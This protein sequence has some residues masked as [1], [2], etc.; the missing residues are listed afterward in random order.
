MR[1]RVVWDTECYSEIDAMLA[2]GID[3]QRLKRAVR[4]AADDLVDSPEAKGDNVSEGLRRVDVD[5]LRV[6]FHV[7]QTQSA[8]I[9]DA[10][11][12]LGDR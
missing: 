1:Y 6:Y 3:G 11:G 12:W 2:A 8:V 7:D 10:I 4:S 9:I 5:I